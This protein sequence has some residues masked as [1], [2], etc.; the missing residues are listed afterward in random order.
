MPYLIRNQAGGVDWFLTWKGTYT[1]D[2]TKA[3]RF[4]YYRSALRLRTGPQSIIFHPWENE[5][6]S[7]LY[8]KH[9][10]L[11]EALQALAAVDRGLAILGDHGRTKSARKELRMAR[12]RLAVFVMRNSGAIRPETAQE[13]DREARRL[14]REKDVG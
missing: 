10:A 3:R 14:D 6:P 13:K 9:K 1:P 11:Q 5:Q 8:L 2:R 12:Q 4:D 7:G